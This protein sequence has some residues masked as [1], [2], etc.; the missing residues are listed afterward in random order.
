MTEYIRTDERLDVL[1]SLEQCAFSLKQTRRSGR[2]WKWVVIS[3]HSALQGAMV[4]HLT[5]GESIGALR[6]GA[7]ENRR[8]WHEKWRFTDDP[9][10]EPK[11]MKIADTPEL[12]KRLKD[13]SKRY[14]CGGG[15]IPIT[16]KQDKSFERLHKGLRNQFIH[17]HPQGWSIEEA[18]IEEVVEDIIEVI[19][20]IADDPYPFRHMEESD[21]EMLDSKIEEIREI[22]RKGS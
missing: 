17:F 2:A 1:S 20:L 22:I 8:A 7:A 16:P 19:G 3:L 6:K 4:C 5:G 21:R 18:L 10:P 9:G 15:E 12:F 11:G 13:S 14:E